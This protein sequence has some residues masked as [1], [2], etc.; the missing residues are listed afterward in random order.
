MRIGSAAAATGLTKKAI[1]Y[2]E[3]E[4]LVTP[5]IDPRSGY[6]E[7]DDDAIVRLE[8]IHTLR[9]LDVPVAEIR[10]VLAGDATLA[11]ALRRSLERTTERIERLQEGSLILSALL[12]R[13]T[14]TAA[15]VRD[16]VQRLRR[17]VERSREERGL[18]LAAEVERIFPGSFGR[19]MALLHAPFFDVELETA[20]QKVQWLRFVTYLDEL[21]EPPPDHP[22]FQLTQVDD[23]AAV[24]AYLEG[25]R[26]H[27]QKLLDEDPEAVATLREA[28]AEFLRTLAA[29]PEAR[30]RHAERLAASRDLWET[31]GA[32]GDEAFN[33]HLAALNDDYRRYLAI[34]QRIRDDVEREVG[35]RLD[36]GSA[37]DA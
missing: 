24:A 35:Y 18:H 6:R 25:Q 22:F 16:E 30:R 14:L 28:L 4:G 34:G 26:E 3:A 1:K 27:V 36:E 2:Y 29:D 13:S 20:E 19:F 11:V 33:E 15:D 5:R 37:S 8:L 17:S 32:G 9:L 10:E 12:A 23:E 21:Q 7:Y 31:I